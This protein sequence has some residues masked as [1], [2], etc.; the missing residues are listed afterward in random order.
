MNA[1]KYG[2]ALACM[3]L[4]IL[5]C[6]SWAQ[7]LPPWKF[8][9]TSSKV[10][11]SFRTDRITR[12][13][14]NALNYRVWLRYDALREPVLLNENNPKSKRY[15]Y[16]VV[17]WII[18]CKA[19]QYATGSQTYYALDG[20]VVYTDEG[21]PLAASTVVPE[22]LGDSIVSAVCVHVGERK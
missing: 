22:T 4:M 17:Q 6:T 5:S 2:R 19:D 8:I 1:M 10:A 3:T 7:Q 20:N 14:F 12:D 13:T 15:S 21:N 18:N 9:T 11:I 16:A